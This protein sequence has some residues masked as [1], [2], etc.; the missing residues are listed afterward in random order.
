M[1]ACLQCLAPI[2]ELRDH[3]VMQDYFDVVSDGETTMTRNNFDFSNRLH[4]F[5]GTVY[6]KSSSDRR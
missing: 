4:E 3:Y 6:S 5:Y 1:N 2:K